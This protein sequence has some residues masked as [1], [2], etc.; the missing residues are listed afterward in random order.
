[1]K[2]QV[3]YNDFKG[4]VA[5]DS[6]EDYTLSNFLDSVGI[7]TDR[8]EPVGTRFYPHFQ[9]GLAVKAICLDKERSTRET[10]VIVQIALDEPVKYE[11]YFS[12][13]KRF[14]AYIVKDHY[15]QF[16]VFESLRISELG[17][18]SGEE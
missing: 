3:K 5:A 6:H 11:E 1:M 10:P 2:A 7:D 12:L 17:K 4:S 15:Q 14:D 8:Y 18:G 9:G 16:E 13:F